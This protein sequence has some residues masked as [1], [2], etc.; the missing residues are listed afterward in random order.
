MKL[1]RHTCALLILLGSSLALSSVSAQ[2]SK[3]GPTKFDDFGYLNHENYSARLDNIATALEDEP[4]AQGYFIFYDG[5]RSL[6]GAAL[7]YVKRLQNYL[8]GPRGIDPSRIILLFGGQREEMIVEFWIS[9]PGSPA[10]S[11]NPTVSVKPA[12][13]QSYLYDS[14]SYDCDPLFRPRAKAPDYIDECAYSGAGYEDQSAR[15]DG[16]IKAISQTP[17]VTAHLRVY[18]LPRDRR[19][20]VQN[21]IQREKYY[22]ASKGLNGSNVTVVSR[23]VPKDRSVELWVMSL[24]RPK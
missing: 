8:A 9:P 19:Q 1:G 18:Y 16:F 17:G 2:T 22:L 11:P 3:Q 5:A 24:K 7:R 6:P 15:L 4:N 14:Y 21:F 10:P 12:K 20:K 23:R 13:A